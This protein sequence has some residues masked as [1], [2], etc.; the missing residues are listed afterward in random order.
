MNRCIRCSVDLLEPLGTGIGIGELHGDPD[1]LADVTDGRGRKLGHEVD[2]RLLDDELG[3]ALLVA[4]G[5]RKLAGIVQ[6]NVVDLEP[7]LLAVDL[8][9]NAVRLID[10]LPV[11][12]PLGDGVALAQLDLEGRLLLSGRHGQGFDLL[13]ELWWKL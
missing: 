7:L 1:I 6:L 11:L 8:E 10:L 2:L 5:A 9:M 3:R 4:D 12:E 13:R